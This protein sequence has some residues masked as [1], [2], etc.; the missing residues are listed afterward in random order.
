ME[1]WRNSHSAEEEL[2]ARE[3]FDIKQFPDDNFREPEE[4]NCGWRFADSKERGNGL[5][6]AGAP[7]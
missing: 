3:F 7:P 4:L 1:E 2:F 5:F 6:D